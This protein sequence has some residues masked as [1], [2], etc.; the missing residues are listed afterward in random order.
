MDIKAVA[1]DGTM[2][3]IKASQEGDNV[4][5]L[6]V[7][8]IVD[9]RRHDVKVVVSDDRYAPV[10][11][12]NVKGENL[13]LKAFTPEG[14]QLDVKAVRRTGTILHI[15]V[16]GLGGRFFGVKAISPNGRMYDVKGIKMTKDRV[17]MLI[18]NVQIHAHV[19]ALPQVGRL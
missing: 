13:D 2:Y 6:E 1:A 19:K 4:H 16:L 8:A 12:I 3:D 17:E 7:K 18:G 9:G 5:M 14:K 11:A 15:K 10:M